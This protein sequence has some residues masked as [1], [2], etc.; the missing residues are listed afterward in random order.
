[1]SCRAG[2]P[3]H[4]LHVGAGPARA[5]AGSAT[6]QRCSSGLSQDYSYFTHTRAVRV[7][8]R[9]KDIDLP[10]ALP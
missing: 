9:V 7:L 6:G 4:L 2:R 10:V 3:V 1:M 5:G 8:V